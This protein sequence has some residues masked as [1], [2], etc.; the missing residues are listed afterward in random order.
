MEIKKAVKKIAALGVGATMMGATLLGAMATPYTLAEY[1]AP[2]VA[3]GQWNGLMVVGDDAAP[4]DI[5][6]ITDIAME[7]QF[8]ATVTKTV[9]TG[10]VGTATTVEGDSWEAKTSS[11]LWEIGENFTAIKTKLDDGDLNALASG[12]LKNNKGSFDYEQQLEFFAANAPDVR[13]S[14]S[15]DD[16]VTADYLYIADGT[17]STPFAQYKFIFKQSAESDSADDE[18][19][20]FSNEKITILGQ[21]FT[22]VSTDNSSIQLTLMAGSV[23]DVMEEGETKTYTIGDTEYEVTALIISDTTTSAKFKVNGET[24]DKMSEGEIELLSDGTQIGIREILANEAGETAGGDIVEFY[25]GADKIVLKD[26]NALEIN[27][28]NIDD[29]LIQMDGSFA[30]ESIT[31]DGFKINF[32][33]DD[34]T[35]IPA[36]GKLSEY[37][38]EP[39]G[40]LNWDMYYAGLTAEDSEVIELSNVGDEEYNLKVEVADGEVSIPFWHHNGSHY[41]LGD[42]D[43]T[44]ND[45]RLLIDL[46]NTARNIT[47]DDYFFLTTGGANDVGD[48]TYVFQYK[49]ADKNTSTENG[50]LKFKN[51]ATGETVERTFYRSSGNSELTVGGET[52]T[53]DDATSSSSNDFN[54]TLSSGTTEDGA[55]VTKYG[56]KIL[57]KNYNASA[58]GNTTISPYD[59]TKAMNSTQIYDA[60]D[61]SEVLLEI[62]AVDN[63]MLEAGTAADNYAFDIRVY[64]DQSTTDPQVELQVLDA[65]TTEYNLESHEEDDDLQTAYNKYGAVLEYRSPS[66]SPKTVDIMWPSEQQYA[67][68]FVTSGAVESEV[69]AASG[70]VTYEVPV[71][72]EV[73]ATVLASQVPDVTSANIISVGGSC[74]N[75]VTAEIMGLS[76]PACG[77]ASGLA[78]G[79]AVIK[80]YESG[81][82]VAIVVA[83]WEAEDTTRATRVLADFE[84]YQTAGTLVGTEVKVTGTSL[85]DVTVTPVTAE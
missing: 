56:A 12:T 66:S 80:L 20:D 38:D 14:V 72:I 46:D 34:N 10:T 39:E 17:T 64:G 5:V 15:E 24:T 73:G 49:G 6:G 67:Q 8:S 54:I 44:W 26:A 42:K 28:E 40:L 48:E 13:Y 33:V 69:G 32:T 41:K 47:K 83:G 36:G 79:E 27:E 4:A 2:F 11:K 37:M 25:L 63:D 59:Y 21:E 78:E 65:D 7:L 29:T 68:V 74:I 53:F 18:W 50:K 1:P 55:I 85:T 77:E 3:D 19:D 75:K 16:D 43:N 52:Y 82:T 51:L 58:T 76:Y 31:W 35:F 81:E 62:N 23:Q 84:A 9:S 22:I 61:K 71:K 70:D 45:E 60:A 57:I 30:T